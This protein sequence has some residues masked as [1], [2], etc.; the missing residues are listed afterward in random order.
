M[1]KSE[2]KKQRQKRIAKLPWPKLRAGWLARWKRNFAVIRDKAADLWADREIYNEFRDIVTANPKI[3]TRAE[4]FHLVG[5]MYLNIALIAIRRFDDPNLASNSFYNLIEEISDQV[6]LLDKAWFVDRFRTASDG[7]YQFHNHWGG[8]RHVS[9]RI[10]NADLNSL[11]RLC[12]RIRKVANKYVA[13]E[14]RRKLNKP[15]TFA[16]VDTAID[17]IYELVNRYHA[18][19]FNS[20]YGTP[21][22]IPSAYVFSIP[23]HE[24]RAR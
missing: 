7:E 2:W 10:V 24:Q 11:V 15:L 5:R 9:K 3:D 22:I 19:I 23:W 12:K 21:M 6:S 4:F 13:H 16:E 18:L 20:G 1:L 17:G 8:R 14:S